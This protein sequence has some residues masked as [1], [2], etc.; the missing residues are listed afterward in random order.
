MGLSLGATESG[1]EA[2]P[3]ASGRHSNWEN[4][5]AEISVPRYKLYLLFVNKNLTSVPRKAY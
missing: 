5:F 4:T 2:V 1:P 3:Y